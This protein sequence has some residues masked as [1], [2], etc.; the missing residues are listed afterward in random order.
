MG[1]G[2]T[3]EAGDS[4]EGDES[5]PQAVSA[6]IDKKPNDGPMVQIRIF[7]FYQIEYPT[8]S[9]SVLKTDSIASQP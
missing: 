4:V 5:P 9:E 3:G 8:I 2:S 7:R 6:S 1:A